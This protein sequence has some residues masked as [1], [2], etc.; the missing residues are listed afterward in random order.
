MKATIVHSLLTFAMMLAVGCGK[1]DDSGHAKTYPVSGTVTVNGKPV[2][3][4]TVTFHQTSGTG[5]S[6]GATDSSGK[7]TL[8]TF[9]SN[10]GAPPGQ[11]KVSIAKYDA[12]AKG[13]TTTG[14]PP[15]QLASGDLDMTRDLEVGGGGAAGGSAG[16]KSLLPD[17]YANQLS[18]GLI[19]TVGEDESKNVFNFDLK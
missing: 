2:E 8:S 1:S 16:P 15:G 13:P 11:Y 18:S 14:P 19:A 6:I 3:G 12:S 5:T 7:Y 10:D 17:K 4:A 9:A